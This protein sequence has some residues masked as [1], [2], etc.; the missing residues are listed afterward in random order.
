MQ[1][2]IPISCSFST[3]IKSQIQWFTSLLYSFRCTNIITTN[4]TKLKPEWPSTP[5]L[6][7]HLPT[8]PHSKRPNLPFLQDKA[9]PIHNAHLLLLQTGLA[10]HN[11]KCPTG[12]RCRG[13]SLLSWRVEVTGPQYVRLALYS[14][15]IYLK[16]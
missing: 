16:F 4:G 15:N 11:L 12:T 13:F 2:R 3:Y 8:H 14:Y 5:Y 1:S 9:L 6:F 10:H 7:Y